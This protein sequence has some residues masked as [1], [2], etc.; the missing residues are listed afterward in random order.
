M[1]CIGEGLE[2]V[3]NNDRE[4]CVG[5]IRGRSDSFLNLLVN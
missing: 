1:R 3:R 4:R 2:A 5:V